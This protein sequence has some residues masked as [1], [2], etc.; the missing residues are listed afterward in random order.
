V[1]NVDAP[2]VDEAPTQSTGSSSSVS[3]ASMS[4]PQVVPPPPQFAPLSQ[5]PRPTNY[6]FTFPSMYSSIPPP[7]HLTGVGGPG[8]STMLSH[9]PIAILG[10]PTSTSGFKRPYSDEEAASPDLGRKRGPRHCVKCGSAMCKGKGGRQFCGNACQDCGNMKCRG[11]N[12]RKAC[13]QGASPIS[14]AA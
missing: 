1:N 6:S 5:P 3:I 14:S 4:Q 13:D 10:T 2:P 12:G 9:P 7:P 8:P 11:R